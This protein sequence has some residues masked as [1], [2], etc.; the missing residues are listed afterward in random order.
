VRTLS[1]LGIGWLSA[2]TTIAASALIAPASAKADIAVTSRTPAVAT[3]GEAVKVRV[4]SGAPRSPVE[5]PI[6]LVPLDL[7]PN[8]YPCAPNAFC[9][10]AA[11]GPPRIGPF[12][13][14]GRAELLPNSRPPIHRY[15]LRFRVPHLKPGRYAFVIYCGGCQPGPR[16]SLLV[17]TQV[18][19]DLLRV[20]RRPDRASSDRGVESAS[21]EVGAGVVVLALGGVLLLIHGHRER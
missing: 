20:I 4:E 8:P 1:H 9:A 11:P 17:Y 3:V 19:N 21:W 15:R 5:F 18:R 13:Y 10:P 16:G 12:D 6:S 7:A 2:A 14:V